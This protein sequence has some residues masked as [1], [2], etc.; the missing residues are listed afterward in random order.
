MSGLWRYGR[1]M[2]YRAAL[3]SCPGRPVAGLR[4]LSMQRYSTEERGRLNTVD[5][6]LYFKNAEGKFISPFH[7]IPLYS[8]NEEEPDV[9]A[10]KSKSNWHKNVMNM[11]VEVPR[12]TNAKMETWEDPSHKDNDTNCCGDNDPID[13]CEIGSKVC[14]RGAVIQV[15]PLGVLG[16]IDEGEMDW[17]IIAINID[18]PEADKFNDIEDVKK[19]KPGYLEATVEW[20]KSYKVPDGKPENQFGFNGEFKDQAF[21][22]E[23][24]KA[25]H[26]YWKDMVHKKSDCN[27]IVCKNVLVSNSPFC[28]SEEE[29]TAIVQS[30][31]SPGESSSVSSES[32]YFIFAVR[33]CIM[34]CRTMHLQWGE[35]VHR[36]TGSHQ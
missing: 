30:A 27:D 7:D 35:I 17:K 25:T 1:L 19:Y 23:I 32:M 15:K 3:T 20:L 12:W 8:R 31:P 14:S 11:V 22:V 5:Y 33:L 29:A 21:A 18:D 24:I 13:V 4:R 9:P 34:Y 2:F 10:K 16:L 36:L 26:G 6:R 28:C